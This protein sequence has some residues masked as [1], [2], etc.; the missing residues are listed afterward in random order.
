MKRDRFSDNK[1]VFQ[2]KL[3]ATDNFG[4]HSPGKQYNTGVSKDNVI[5]KKPNYT[6]SKDRKTSKKKQ[7]S[8]GPSS[9]RVAN[10]GGFG[11]K[12]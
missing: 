9:Y 12:G 8:P 11:A 6:F 3:V 7:S 10:I 1:K 5:N 2:P 4:K